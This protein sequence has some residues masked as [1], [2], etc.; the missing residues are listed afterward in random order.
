MIITNK[1]AIEYL[2]PVAESATLTNYQQALRLAIEAL[3][4]F[5]RLEE[6]AAQQALQNTLLTNKLLELDKR[7][8]M[9]QAER[10]VVTKR[11][12]EL[13]REE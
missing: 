8:E 3:E 4:N 2:R 12:I 10:D 5:E 13:E 7:L 11:M 9:A 6:I 1:E